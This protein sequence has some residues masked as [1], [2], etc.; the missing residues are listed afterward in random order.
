MG[1]QNCFILAGFLALICM[2][3]F[4]LLVWKGKDLRR[5]SAKTYWKYVESS[6][7]GH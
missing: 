2:G 4:V 3:T 5:G 7:G 1:L 6:V